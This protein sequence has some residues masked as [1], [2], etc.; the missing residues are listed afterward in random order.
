MPIGAGAETPADVTSL[1]STLVQPLF[2]VKSDHTLR[3]P[4]L[5]TFSRASPWTVSLSIVA[6]WRSVVVPGRPSVTS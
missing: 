6:A 3:I 4:L 1:P 2:C 5:V